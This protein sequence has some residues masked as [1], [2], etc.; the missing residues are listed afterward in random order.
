MECAH[1]RFCNET[2]LELPGAHDKGDASEHT[3]A[4]Q[5]A[6]KDLEH[7]KSTRSLNETPEELTYWRVSS[8]GYKSLGACFIFYIY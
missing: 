2:H 3:T 5:A 6:H 8:S 4:D 7:I 1:E